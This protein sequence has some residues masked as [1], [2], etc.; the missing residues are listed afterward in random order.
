MARAS[1]PGPAKPSRTARTGAE[2]MQM[3]HLRT[4]KQIERLRKEAAER[5]AIGKPVHPK[6]V[7]RA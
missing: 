1:R 7:Y 5:L 4:R 2:K 3:N 6:I